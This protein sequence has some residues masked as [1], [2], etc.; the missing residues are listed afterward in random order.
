M[1]EHIQKLEEENV[2]L[3]REIQEKDRQL[4]SGL[5]KDCSNHNRNN[6]DSTSISGTDK[7]RLK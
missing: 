7:D 3:Q 4:M 1:D 6:E 5:S 2:F